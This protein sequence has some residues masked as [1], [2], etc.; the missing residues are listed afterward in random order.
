MRGFL[1]CSPH[2]DVCLS[3]DIELLA[4]ASQAN[5]FKLDA[6]RLWKESMCRIWRVALELEAL[7]LACEFPDYH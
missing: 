5:E 3:Q 4:H 2:V 7:G 1:L 6:T